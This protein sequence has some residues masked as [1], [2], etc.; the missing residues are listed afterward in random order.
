MALNTQFLISQFTL[1]SVLLTE[2]INSKYLVDPFIEALLTSPG[3]SPDELRRHSEEL[4]NQQTSEIISS[5][6]NSANTQARKML[7]KF[8]HQP[9]QNPSIN[10]VSLNSS[11]EELNEVL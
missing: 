5:L 1:Q 4:W 7:D 11:A 3:Y 2:W 8:K 10:A 6:R 9:V